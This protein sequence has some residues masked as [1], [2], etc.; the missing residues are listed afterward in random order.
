MHLLRSRGTGKGAP[1]GAAFSRSGS[2]HRGWRATGFGR[3]VERLRVPLMLCWWHVGVCFTLQ[4]E[5]AWWYGV[6]PASGLSGLGAQLVLRQG[7][8][9]AF[10]TVLAFAAV[11]VLGT[12]FGAL[13]GFATL[14]VLLRLRYD[15]LPEPKGV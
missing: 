9:F 14:S 3:A 10:A 11:S 15:Q 2:G 13:A 6:Q 7:A 4:A 1:V 5:N 12:G 8:V